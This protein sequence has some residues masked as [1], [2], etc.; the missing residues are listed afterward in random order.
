M[1]LKLAN[2]VGRD[3]SLLLQDFLPQGL[4]APLLRG[5]IQPFQDFQRTGALADCGQRL[6]HIL[7]TVLHVEHGESQFDGLDAGRASIGQGCRRPIG[8]LPQTLAA[9]EIEEAVVRQRAFVLL[10][11][12]AHVFRNGQGEFALTFV[13]RALLVCV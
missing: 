13:D 7:R 9:G 10:Q 11:C 1:Q 3:R 12:A 5:P 4:Q 6:L 8:F 2:G